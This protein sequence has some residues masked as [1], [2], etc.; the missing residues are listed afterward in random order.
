[1]AIEIGFDIT[2]MEYHTYSY[3]TKIEQWLV[4]V[5]VNGLSRFIFI[6]NFYWDWLLL[7]RPT[8]VYFIL[9]NFL[10]G[11]SFIDRT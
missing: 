7:I 11:E 6:Y 9:D 5:E 10:L 1:M 3:V 2:K 4:S 8:D